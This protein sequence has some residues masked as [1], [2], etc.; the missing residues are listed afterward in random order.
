M[1]LCEGSRVG[2]P[3]R[4]TRHRNLA[5]RT[6]RRYPMLARIVGRQADHFDVI[7]EE[8][9]RDYVNGQF[10][11]VER[12]VMQI[13][14]LGKSPPNLLAVYDCSVR[15]DFDG[16]RIGLPHH[17]LPD[18]RQ[19]R[20]PHVG[21]AAQLWFGSLVAQQWILPPR[22]EIHARGKTLVSRI[23]LIDVDH[24]DPDLHLRRLPPNGW[25]LQFGF[26]LLDEHRRFYFHLLPGQGASGVAKCCAARC[27]LPETTKT[28][29]QSSE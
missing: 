12:E 20:I 26:R 21:E 6:C 14:R 7:F 4:K 18:D 5:T 1:I 10:L 27:W 19:S 2:V 3:P 24:V 22:F 17:L 16:I 13:Q 8:S 29:K 15:S 28:S 25:S 11:P 9:R 23:H